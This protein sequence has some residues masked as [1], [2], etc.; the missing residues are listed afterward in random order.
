MATRHPFREV[1]V[2]RVMTRRPATIEED[3][4]LEDAAAAMAEGGFRHLPV[5][6]GDGRLVGM[7]SERDLR[8]RLGT[9]VGQFAD[10]ATDVL[11]EPVSAVMTPD[12]IALGPGS[13]LA[14]ALEVFADERIGAVPVTDGGDRVVGIV[15]YLDLLDWF[16]VHGE[17][18]AALRRPRA[19]SA[20]RRRAHAAH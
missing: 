4:P 14:A 18:A 10:V 19:S 15:S 9:D 11:H 6:D 7:L 20:P 3:A 13:T 8:A 16:R 17:R 5:V 12:P 1:P 2:E